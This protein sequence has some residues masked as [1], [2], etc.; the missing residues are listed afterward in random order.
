MCISTEF[1]FDLCTDYKDRCSYLFQ[2]KKNTMMGLSYWPT[3]STDY[4]PVGRLQIDRAMMW[5]A[6][7]LHQRLATFPAFFSLPGTVNMRAIFCLW[8]AVVRAEN[9]SPVQHSW[10]PSA[11]PP[12]PYPPLLPSD[13]QPGSTS[14]HWYETSSWSLMSTADDSL[15]IQSQVSNN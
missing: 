9:H 15:L 13:R 14:S 6:W 4:A 2:K 7:G 5:W 12:F 1:S 8:G 3:Y 10:L 11:P